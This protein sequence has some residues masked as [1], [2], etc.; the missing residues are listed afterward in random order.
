[1]PRQRRRPKVTRLY[2]EAQLVFAIRPPQTQDA[3]KVIE[4]A[5]TGVRDPLEL[6]DKS[7]EAFRK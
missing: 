3:R 2:L 6:R 4:M 7:L 5:Q 1:M